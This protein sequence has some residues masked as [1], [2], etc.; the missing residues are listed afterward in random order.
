V[1]EVLKKYI[2]L[3]IKWKQ[4]RIEVEKYNFLYRWNYITDITPEHEV[5]MVRK[6]FNQSLLV[7][8]NVSFNLIGQ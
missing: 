3:L 7:A 2:S 6:C 1:G 8:A 5:E 4:L